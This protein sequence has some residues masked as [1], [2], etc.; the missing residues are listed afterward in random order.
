M[1]GN[2]PPPPSPWGS[3]QGCPP[4]P[5]ALAQ[6]VYLLLSPRHRTQALGVPWPPSELVSKRGGERNPRPCG[7]LGHLQP[8]LPSTR[9]GICLLSAFVPP[10]RGG[11]AGS[12]EEGGGAAVQLLY[13]ALGHEDMGLR[14]PHSAESR[15]PPVH[16][17][18]VGFQGTEDSHC[19]GHSRTPTCKVL[20]SRRPQN[21]H[22]RD[23]EVMQPVNATVGRPPQHRPLL[24]IKEFT[25]GMRWGADPDEMLLGLCSSSPSFRLQ[26][27]EQLY[28]PQGHH[29][30]R[31]SFQGRGAG[32]IC[33]CGP[34]KVARALPDPEAPCTQEP[35]AGCQGWGAFEGLDIPL[36]S[37]GTFPISPESSRIKDHICKYLQLTH[38]LAIVRPALN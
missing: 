20:C 23:G 9:P 37:F 27:G 30:Q 5:S 22:L 11:G 4:R 35:A 36:L 24:L 1:F 19:A 15:R 13:L 17:A 31:L 33:R 10:R 32:P 25:A 16:Q 2:A 7:D 8:F 12:K 14:S 26:G 18:E 38:L 29:D 34:W 6:P 3:E 21:S 28:T